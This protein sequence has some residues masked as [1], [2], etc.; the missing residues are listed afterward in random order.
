MDKI[1]K[2]N[3]AFLQTTRK[4]VPIATANGMVLI[5]QK[6]HIE[7][8]LPVSKPNMIYVM[9]NNA[10]NLRCLYC[11]IWKFKGENDLNT[12]Q[13]IQAFDEL[14]SWTRYP[15][16]NISGG[17]PFIRKDIFQILD[18]VV[19]KGAVVGVVT[20]GWALKPD[21]VPRVV[22]LGLSNLNISIDSLDHNVCDMMRGRKGHTKKTIESILRVMEEIKRQ[23]S[24]MK[25]YLKAVVS[26][27]N[28]TSLVDIVRFAQ[29]NG[30]SG[31]MFQPLEAVFSRQVDYGTEWHKNTPLWP[32]ELEE[33]EE[34]TNELIAM[35]KKGAP[36]TN[37]ISHIESWPKYFKNPITGVQGQIKDLNLHQE[38]IPCRIGHTHLYMNSDGTFKLCWSFPTLGNVLNDSIKEKWNSRQAK[39]LRESIAKC[40]AP[41]TK[42]CLLDRGFS[43]TV[44]TFFTLMKPN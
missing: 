15:K 1:F 24:D 7:T 11:D 36:I 6:L 14:L 42:T 19:K 16:L 8:G 27:A 3:K 29:K 35:K 43:E 32:Q 13:W 21:I 2:K 33:L 41:C 39:D 23:Q 25:V 22:E 10:C 37:P 9:I 38:K 34:A 40:T 17:E 4:L 30:I 5:R 44:K 28:A 18:F 26:G 12:Q 31:V 20:N